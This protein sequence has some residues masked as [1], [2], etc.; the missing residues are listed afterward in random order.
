MFRARM[1][2]GV[3]AVQQ[4]VMKQV[5]KGLVSATVS[6]VKEFVKEHPIATAAI[7]STAGLTAAYFMRERLQRLSFKVRGIQGESARPG[8]QIVDDQTAWPNCQVLLYEA[9]PLWSNFIGC[10]VRVGD[11]LV[12]YSHV[13]QGVD[14]LVAKTP[15]GSF[16]VNAG[17]VLSGRLPD[18]CYYQLS[19][20]LWSQMGTQSANKLPVPEQMALRAQPAMVWSKEGYTQGTLAP[21]HLG[22]LKMEYSGT[23]QPGFSGAPYMGGPNNAKVLGLHQ[24]V[25]EGHNVGFIW[26]AIL[27]DIKHTFFSVDSF[28]GERSKS[29][30]IQSGGDDDSRNQMAMQYLQPTTGR[31]AWSYR[32]LS[33]QI[34][35]ME[36]GPSDW[37][38]DDD[39]FAWNADL[40]FETVA[41]TSQPVDTVEKI[42][43]RMEV[44]S[45][46]NLEALHRMAEALILKK[47]SVVGQSP[48]SPT[49]DG[50]STMVEVTIQTCNKYTDAKVAALEKRVKELEDSQK[51]ARTND[52]KKEKIPPPPPKPHQCVCLSRFRTVEGLAAHQ[53]VK[54]CKGE[55]QSAPFLGGKKRSPTYENWRK[56]SSSVGRSQPSKPTPVVPGNLADI[57]S[58]LVVTLNGVLQNMS[59]QKSDPEQNLKA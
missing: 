21:L 41:G 32:G 35:R 37:V 9:G 52:F 39:D 50:G 53:Q 2:M 58:E 42:I 12:T 45:Q 48:D 18:V 55:R 51:M 8:S 13:V 22:K 23:T 43:D 27:E 38:A 34:E 56:P 30:H 7:G 59:G 26:F 40:Q 14:K 17:R 44:L 46:D 6:T 28:A 16:L 49:V 11:W 24:G 19:S 54:G 1:A 36:V 3:Q 25:Q 5:R 57:M 10:G 4:P 20:A 31:A 47:R 33:E 15:K 29:K